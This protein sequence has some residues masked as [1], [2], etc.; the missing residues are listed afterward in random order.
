MERVGVRYDDTYTLLLHRTCIPLDFLLLCVSL[1]LFPCHL[2]VF[3][4]GYEETKFVVKLIEGT[5]IVSLLKCIMHVT[6]KIIHCYSFI[7]LC[8]KKYFIVR[9]LAR[10]ALLIVLHKLSRSHSG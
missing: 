7:L 10:R 5:C 6:L 1:L 2:Q 8:L 4:T 9:V 3:D